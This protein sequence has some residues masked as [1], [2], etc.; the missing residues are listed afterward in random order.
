M[1][2]QEIKKDISN[3]WYD[4]AL[5]KCDSML[6]NFPESKPDILRI[7]A[8]AYSMMGEYELALKDRESVLNIPGNCTIKDYYSAADTALKT[9]NFHQ[10]VNWFHEVL[11]LGD[12]LN[13]HWFDSA[14]YFLLSYTYMELKEYDMAIENLNNAVT[15]EENCTMP[16]P[17]QGMCDHNKL[18]EEILRRRGLNA[19]R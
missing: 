10:A 3:K 2:I 17:E 19:R 18:R 9:G 4:I 16:I 1:D 15:I 5:N 6:R 7:R 8:H 14:S 11:H 13:N 12:E